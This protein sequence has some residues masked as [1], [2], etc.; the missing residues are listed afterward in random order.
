MSILIRMTVFQ[1]STIRLVTM[2]IATAV[3]MRNRRLLIAS[4]I[5]RLL[6]VMTT[7]LKFDRFCQKCLAVL[8]FMAVSLIFQS[9]IWQKMIQFMKIFSSLST[10]K[11]QKKK[12]F[13]KLCCQKATIRFPA[14][15]NLQRYCLKIVRN[16]IGLSR[17]IYLNVF[18]LVRLTLIR[19]ICHRA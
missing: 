7:N 5:L 3:T 13:Y 17:H 19:T 14:E 2:T 8:K 10:E 16:L 1:K 12:S 15:N 11:K 6:F 9:T 18:D 4:T